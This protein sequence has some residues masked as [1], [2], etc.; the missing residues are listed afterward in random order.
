MN[1]DIV[2]K[3]SLA[4]CSVT[5]V[6]CNCLH[7]SWLTSFSTI[8]TTNYSLKFPI[9]ALKRVTAIYFFCENEFVQIWKKEDQQQIWKN[10]FEETEKV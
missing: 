6:Y 8:S 3:Q 2:C 7:Q 5:I 10:E 1:W 4:Y 9:E